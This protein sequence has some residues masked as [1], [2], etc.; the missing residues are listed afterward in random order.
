M[1]HSDENGGKGPMM[2]KD[3]VR[4]TRSLNGELALSTYWAKVCAY[5]HLALILPLKMAWDWTR[6]G[7][8]LV[9]FRLSSGRRKIVGREAIKPIALYLPQFHAFPENDAWWGRGFTEWTNVK[10][11]VPLYQGHHEPHVPHPDIGYYDLTDVSVM[12]KQ[13]EIAKAH[14]LYGFCFY[15]YH[16]KGGKRLLEKPLENWLAAH[17]IDFPFC[18]AWA[19]ENWTRTWDGGDNEILMPQ[20][21]NAENLMLMMRNMLKDFADPRYIKTNGGKTPVLLVY[22]A[23]LIPDCRKITSQWRALAREAGFDDLFL[24]SMQ[25]AAEVDP[26]KLG[27]DAATDFASWR[28]DTFSAMK[29]SLD[30]EDY[31]VGDVYLRVRRYSAVVERA[32]SP[33]RRAAYPRFRMACPDWDNTPRRGARGVSLLGSTPELF[34]KMFRGCCDRTQEDARLAKHGFVFV[35]AWNEWGEGAHLEPDVRTGYAYLNVIKEEMK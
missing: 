33:L 3:V 20:D 1:A 30:V 9:A 31:R 4:A 14:G 35:N 5:P 28:C 25:N 15:Y 17:D 32:I 12:R 19:N 11:A 26:R 18:Y 22:R 8:K 34:G 6:Y 27:F 23:E 24:I 13:A 29:P 10:K 16:F 7:M 21:Y 2:K